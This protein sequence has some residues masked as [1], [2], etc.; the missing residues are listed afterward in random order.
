[1]NRVVIKNFRNV[2]TEGLCYD[3]LVNPIIEGR[4]AKGR[5]YGRKLG[6]PTANLDRRQYHMDKMNLPLGIYAGVVYLHHLKRI[7]K[8][9]VVIG[10]LDIN[11]LPKIEAHILGFNGQLYGRKLTLYLFKFLRPFQVFKNEKLLTAQIK[12]DIERV[13]SEVASP[14]PL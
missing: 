11:N 9:A 6:F 13:E 3:S 4:V 10:P 14:V 5:G 8:A 7:R 12:K 2:P 1:M